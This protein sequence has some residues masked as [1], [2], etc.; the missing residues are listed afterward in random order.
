MSRTLFV[1]SYVKPTTVNMAEEK[2]AK[3]RILLSAVG[4]IT[5]IC[6]LIL[7]IVQA[8][9]ALCA[10]I[11]VSLGVMLWCYPEP[12]QLNPAVPGT[13]EITARIIETTNNSTITSTGDLVING[14]VYPLTEN[15]RTFI[16]QHLHEGTT[17]H[18]L[19]LTRYNTVE[20]VGVIL[21]N[22]P[23]S[24]YENI[25]DTAA[26]TYMVGE[27]NLTPNTKLDNLTIRL[28]GRK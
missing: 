28:F 26:D 23:Y 20:A 3:M 11:L 13:L 10:L 5:I 9:I 7:V 8:F 12:Y 14:I 25:C 18:L 22:I 15:T 6:A 16:T 2:V 21:D 4:F 19:V 1:K 27:E 24:E 17:T